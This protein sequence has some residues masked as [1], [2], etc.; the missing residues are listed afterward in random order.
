MNPLTIIPLPYRL[1]GLVLLA[2]ALIGFSWLKGANHVRD[3]WDAANTKQAMQMSGFKQR[4]AEATVQVVTKYVDRVKVVRETGETIIK[5]L[6]I[7]V[8]PEADVACV[9]SRGFVRLHDAA[10]AGRIPFTAGAAD[11]TPAGIAL[12]TAAD[13]VVDNYER[14]HENAEQLIALQSWIRSIIETPETTDNRKP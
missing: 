7:Y 9:L 14:C 13:T 12:S 10:V 6:P 2:A 3:E 5:E 8:T 11:V 1:L 4:Q